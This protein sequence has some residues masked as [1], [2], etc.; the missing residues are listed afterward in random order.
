GSISLTDTL[1]FNLK[2]NVAAKCSLDGFLIYCV[3][4]NIKASGSTE[5]SVRN[6]LKLEAN[7]ELKEKIYLGTWIKIFGYSI[8]EADAGG[9]PYLNFNAMIEGWVQYSSKSKFSSNWEYSGSGE[10]G[11]FAEIN[12]ALFNGKWGGEIWAKRFPFYKMS[13]SGNGKSFAVAFNSDGGVKEAEP[14]TKKL[15]G[16]DTK[17]DALPIEPQKTGYKFDGW[18]TEKEGGGAEFTADTEV[19]DS[20]T[21]YA[22][23]T[24]VKVVTFNGDGATTE[25]NPS[26]KTIAMTDTKIDALPA[27][28]PQKTGYKFRGWFTEKN[29]GG[30]EFTADTEITNSITVY[31]KWEKIVIS[32]ENIALGATATASSYSSSYF[33]SKLV[34]NI[35]AHPSVWCANGYDGWF[36]IDLGETKLIRKIKLFPDTADP[37]TV[38]FSIEGS[39]DDINWETIDAD[40]SSYAKKNVSTNFYL[41]PDL[42]VN[43][44]YLRVTAKTWGGWF[45]VYEFQ[46]FQIT[47]P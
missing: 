26:I 30:T 31:A 18:F 6:T 39:N 5:Y 8:L 32:T 42:D 17:I 33:P 14:P 9:G 23:W 45:A 20:I 19:T 22:K 47:N 10:L 2:G 21:V 28:A 15:L 35:I 37:G 12:A 40:G 11:V 38:T 7:V 24:P 13:L 1:E 25:A 16:A 29:G 27:G 46:V 34:D 36:K 4:T 3:P 43:Y 41:S 44:R